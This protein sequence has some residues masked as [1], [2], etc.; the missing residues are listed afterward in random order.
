LGNGDAGNQ[1]WL[2]PPGGQMQIV[3]GIKGAATET[4]DLVFDASGTSSHLT[5]SVPDSPNC[6]LS[7]KVATCHPPAWY[8]PDGWAASVEVQADSGTPLSQLGSI[9]VR[10]NAGT[11]TRRGTFWGQRP[12]AGADLVIETTTPTGRVGDTVQVRFSVRNLGPNPEPYWG[13]SIDSPPI[14]TLE[15]ITGCSPVSFNGGGA[16][17][18]GMS[19]PQAVGSSVTFTATFRINRQPV[20]PR[21]A[22][23]GVGMFY[24]L[25][26]PDPG[27]SNGY[28]V[29]A[30]AG[31]G[32]AAAGGA[33]GG[34]A[35]GGGQPRSTQG[36][37]GPT[38]TGSEPTASSASTPSA[39]PAG[40]PSSGS[41][42]GV[43]ASGATPIAMTPASDS[44]SPVGWLAGLA[45]A[46]V[47]LAVGGYAF[48]LVR[49]RLKPSTE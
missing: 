7:G 48:L 25:D 46:V 11:G 41:V 38:P 12:G 18:C 13:L 4:D 27:N 45:V 6:T 22:S 33:A 28:F 3:F 15:S 23:G 26:D 9:V 43:A 14:A 42:D 29:I 39:S 40:P 31:G 47:L 37:T 44:T 21:E 20:Y 24:A 17:P 2:I 19:E 1:T 16:L 34:G 8:P 32:G 36:G 5:L 35:A 10:D 30:M 49:R